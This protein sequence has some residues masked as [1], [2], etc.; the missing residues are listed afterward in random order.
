MNAEICKPQI[1]APVFA[2]R[3]VS[4]AVEVLAGR[5]MKRMSKAE[6]HAPMTPKPDRGAENTRAYQ[7]TLDR[8]CAAVTRQPGATVRV[9]ARETG[10]CQQHAKRAALD[11]FKAGRVDRELVNNAYFRYYPQTEDA[12]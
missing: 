12:E 8:V 10:V 6:G 4:D 3:H 1:I 9:L 2:A 11:L 7:R 5:V